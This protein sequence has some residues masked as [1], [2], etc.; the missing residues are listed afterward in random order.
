MQFAALILVV[1]ACLWAVTSP[2][3]HTGIVVTIGLVLLACGCL[4]ELDGWA[5][6][7]RAEEFQLWGAGFVLWGIFWRIA[8]RPYWLR[9]SMR[10]H[11]AHAFARLWGV[12]RR[13]ERRE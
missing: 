13:E 12:E 4:A 7:D 3:I 9:V 1:C 6:D 5:F 8:L 10:W 2:N 11:P